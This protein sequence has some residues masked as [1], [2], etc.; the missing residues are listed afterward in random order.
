[1][2]VAHDWPRRWLKRGSAV[3]KRIV[4]DL[5]IAVWVSMRNDSVV[6]MRG[7]SR[8]ATEGDKLRLLAIAHQLASQRAKQEY[9]APE[10]PL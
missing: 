2:A 9:R 6:H 7:L 5:T 10:K 4:R 8:E 1:M 3:S